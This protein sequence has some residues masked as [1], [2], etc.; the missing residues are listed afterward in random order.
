VIL[1]ELQIS[2]KVIPNQTRRGRLK[3][4]NNSYLEKSEYLFVVF[5]TKRITFLQNLNQ[6]ILTF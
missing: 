1:E 2:V 4:L 3:L 5:Q 6:K